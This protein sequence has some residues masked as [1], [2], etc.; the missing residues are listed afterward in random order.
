MEIRKESC[1]YHY[2]GSHLYFVDVS[3][4]SDSFNSLKRNQQLPH[5]RFQYSKQR[6][7]EWSVKLCCQRNTDGFPEIFLVQSCDFSDVSSS[8][9]PVLFYVRMVY[10]PCK[11]KAFQAVL[12]PVCVQYGSSFPDGNVYSGKDSR[13]PETEQS[14]QHL[15]YLSGIWSRAGCVYVYRFCKRNSAGN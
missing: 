4:C 9:P 1:S 12:L 7:L 6:N 14:V 11:R 15:H 13:Y 5:L 8:D 10:C 2:P 3:H